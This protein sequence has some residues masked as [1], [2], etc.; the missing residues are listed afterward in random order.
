M[1]I[2]NLILSAVALIG[3][4]YC[5]EA[6]SAHC[7]N[8]EAQKKLMAQHPELQKSITQLEESMNN[9]DLS[10]LEKNHRGDYIIPLVY[11]VLHNYGSENISDAQIYSDVKHLN[12]NYNKKNADTSAV[13]PI[14]K[15]LIANVGFEFRLANKDPEGNCTNGIDRNTYL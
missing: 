3:S 5:V 15:P 7:G 6:Q 2:K 1:S 14:F 10:K 11:H 13:I 8:V 9:I 4:N 12:D